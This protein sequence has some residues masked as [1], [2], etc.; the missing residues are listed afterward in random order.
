MSLRSASEDR[1]LA[2]QR[3]SY[4]RA[5]GRHFLIGLP[6][7]RPFM[8]LVAATGFMKLSCGYV[9]V[10]D[11][12]TDLAHNFQMDWEYDSAMDGNIALTGEIDLSRGTRIYPR[13]GLRAQPAHAAAATLFQSLCI[14]FERN[15]KSFVDQWHRTRKRLAPDRHESRQARRRLRPLCSRA[16]SICCWRTRTSCIP[17]P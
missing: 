2:Q 12:W 16:A 9:G 7:Q 10:S 15:V 14:P 4:C 11:G 6:R 8:A 17:A 5:K 13:P 3:R 1:R